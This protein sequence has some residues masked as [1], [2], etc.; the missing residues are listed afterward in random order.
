METNLS[1]V[2]K[3]V[4]QKGLEGINGWLVLVGIGIVFSPLRILLQ[5]GTNYSKIFSNGAWSALTT[6]GTEA[7][8][9]LW[10]PIILTEVV[11][12]ALLVCAFICLAYLFFTKKSIFPKIYIGVLLFNLIFVVADAFSIKLVLPNEPAFD[13]ETGKEVARSLIANLIWI[14]YMLVS[15]RVKATFVK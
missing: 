14:P 10:A 2:K 12:N 4:E 8:H 13:L 11:I 7:Y 6:P 9:P 5:V 1:E 3:P 15:K